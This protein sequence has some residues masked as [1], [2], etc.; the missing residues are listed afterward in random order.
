[1]SFGITY[2]QILRMVRATLLDTS[3]ARDIV[4]RAGIIPGDVS[5]DLIARFGFRDDY[6]DIVYV[7]Y[8][9]QTIVPYKGDKLLPLGATH[10]A[11]TPDEMGVEIDQGGYY[12]V[13]ASMFV[14][15]LETD[16]PWVTQILACARDADFNLLRYVLL[17]EL[18]FASEPRDEEPGRTGAWDGVNSPYMHGQNVIACNAGE[19]LTI[20]LLVSFLGDPTTSEYYEDGTARVGVNYTLYRQWIELLNP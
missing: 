16:I 5:N 17:D 12:R 13:H 1:M 8:G 10:L 18:Y 15:L 11:K 20:E 4:R 9:E 3:I 14:V 2:K 7:P 19:I 6:E